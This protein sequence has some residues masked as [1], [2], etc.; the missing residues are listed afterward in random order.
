MALFPNEKTITNPPEGK[1]FKRLITPS[2]GNNVEQP[3][4]SYSVN[5][6]IKWYKYFGKSFGSFL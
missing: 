3:E 6:S 5:G 4:L 1:K 2:A